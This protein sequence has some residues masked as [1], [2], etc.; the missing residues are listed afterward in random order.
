MKVHNGGS[1]KRIY[2]HS[3]KHTNTHIYTGIKTNTA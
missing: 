2:K 3:E 1:K